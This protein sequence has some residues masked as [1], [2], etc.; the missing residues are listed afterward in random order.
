MGTGLIVLDAA[1]I[2]RR[3]LGPAFATLARSA[4]GETATGWDAPAFARFARTPG[5]LAVVDAGLARALALAR[6]AADE[7]EIL[8]LGVVAE[9]RR[10]GL[11][12][13]LLGTVLEAVRHRGAARLFLEVAADNAAARALYA[14]AGFAEIGTRRR[15]YTRPGGAVDALVLARATAGGGGSPPP[16]P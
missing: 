6:V 14:G 9:H 13:A 2:G 3:A 15:Y 4:F 8:D 16:L 12:R 1:E 7:A 10:A 11:G 5:G